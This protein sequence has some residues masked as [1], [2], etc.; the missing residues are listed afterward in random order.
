MV[1]ALVDGVNDVFGSGEL[2]LVEH[3]VAPIGVVAHRRDLLAAVGK[4]AV[5]ARTHRIFVEPRLEELVQVALHAREHRFEN[6]PRHDANLLES[7][8]DD[9]RVLSVLV[10]DEDDLA[11]RA[12]G[13]ALT[14]PGSVAPAASG[15]CTSV[16]YCQRGDTCRPRYF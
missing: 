6:V 1:V 13:V 15:T 3:G 7:V 11:R 4:E 16:M 14:V 9:E 5:R 8:E 2:A 12:A 10:E